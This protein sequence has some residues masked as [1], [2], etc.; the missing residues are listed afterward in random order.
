MLV[1]DKLGGVTGSEVEAIVVRAKERAALESRTDVLIK[2]FE[3]AI[4][5]FINPLDPTL[6]MTQKLAAV[7]S[8]SDKR[9]LPEEYINMKK[10]DV[11]ALWMHCK[12]MLE[13]NQ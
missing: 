7:M 5:S 4:G 10:E 6:L 13:G 2:D 8:C 1:S 12:M 9:Y 11:Y 3:E